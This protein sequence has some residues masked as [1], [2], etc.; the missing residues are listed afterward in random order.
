MVG[1]T[2]FGR[3]FAFAMAFQWSSGIQLLASAVFVLRV[4]ASIRTY[5]SMFNVEPSEWRR[6]SGS[7][8]H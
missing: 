6:P 8:L 2:L 7:L 3:V 5:R 1:E 4:P